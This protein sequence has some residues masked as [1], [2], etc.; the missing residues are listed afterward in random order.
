MIDLA[1]YSRMHEANEM[2]KIL[3]SFFETTGSVKC[4]SLIQSRGSATPKEFASVDEYKTVSI[5]KVRFMHATTKWFLLECEPE[6]L[7]R[8]FKSENLSV[9]SAGIP[10]VAKDISFKL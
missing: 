4:V 9:L 1:T 6:P 3:C 8:K 10:V 5:T 7:L 2:W